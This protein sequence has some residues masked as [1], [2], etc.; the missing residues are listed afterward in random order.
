[1]LGKPHA[2]PASRCFAPPRHLGAL[3]QR[4][5]PSG[6]PRPP[7]SA[8]NAQNSIEPGT[9]SPHSAPRDRRGRSP[10]NASAGLG[11]D[12]PWLRRQSLATLQAP[13]LEHG[14]SSPCAHAHP[15]SVSLC[16]LALVRLV[17]PFHIPSLA[18]GQ[19]CDHG[20][21]TRHTSAPT[22]SAINVPPNSHT[23]I[24][25]TRPQ[26]TYTAERRS[27]S[28]AISARQSPLLPLLAFLPQLTLQAYTAPCGYCGQDRVAP[29]SQANRPQTPVDR[30]L[31]LAAP[32]APSTNRSA[33]P[34]TIGA[35]PAATLD[36]SFAS[37][38]CPSAPE[39]A[40]Q[41]QSATQTTP[42]EITFPIFN[43]KLGLCGRCLP[44]FCTFCTGVDSPVDSMTITPA[45]RR[46]SPA[47][48]TP[49]HSPSTT[50]ALHFPRITHQHPCGKTSPAW[51]QWRRGSDT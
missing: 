40:R 33:L 44:G 11:T 8:P 7:S 21:P 28:S 51:V 12:S 13:T 41:A 15:E 18:S 42:T 25:D 47:T 6:R 27:I 23:V 22:L 45:N 39:Q 9:C 2:R 20:R 1:M 32:G 43:R 17:S 49:S 14:P 19:R 50:K 34:R 16:A 5:R 30:R 48:S 35:S 10:Q 3:T 46:Y 37:C 26:S 31:H 38:F 29:R 4:T 24:W 36:L